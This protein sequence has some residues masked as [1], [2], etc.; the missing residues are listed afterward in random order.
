MKQN[1]V[2]AISYP[3]WFTSYHMKKFLHRTDII[4]LNHKSCNFHKLTCRTNSQYFS[5]IVALKVSSCQDV[6]IAQNIP[7]QISAIHFTIEKVSDFQR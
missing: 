2:L 4:L 7:F 5:F 1:K 6:E 3:G